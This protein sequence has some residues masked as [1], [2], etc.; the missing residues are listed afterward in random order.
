[1]K[2]HEGFV[3][4]YQEGFKACG[5]GC[6]KLD[7]VEEG[8]RMVDG[9]LRGPKVSEDMVVPVAVFRLRV[10]DGVRTTHKGLARSMTMNAEVRKR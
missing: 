2:G 8:R 3:A 6:V 7:G 4:E 10:G 5:V 9:C 1:L